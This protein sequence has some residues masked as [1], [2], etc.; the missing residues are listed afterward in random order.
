TSSSGNDDSMS[1]GGRRRVAIG[2]AGNDRV[3]TLG[4]GDTIAC[5]D[6]CHA[7]FSLGQQTL[8]VTSIFNELGGADLLDVHG[9]GGNFTIV[10]GGTCVALEMCVLLSVL[11]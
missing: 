5:G 8:N 6:Y 11:F 9:N 7:T 1:V 4:D 3:S 10:V 2:G